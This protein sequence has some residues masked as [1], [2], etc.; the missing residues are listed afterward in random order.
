MGGAES[1]SAALLLHG[2]A[3]LHMYGS[4]DMGG[5]TNVGRF[6]LS[7]RLQVAF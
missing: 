2:H 1:R 4:S 6:L 5:Y 7:C 3:G